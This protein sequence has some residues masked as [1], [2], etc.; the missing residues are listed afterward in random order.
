MEYFKYFLDYCPA[1]HPF[2]YLDGSYCCATKFEK[3]SDNNG[4]LHL[5]GSGYKCD[6]S[7]IQKDS[8]CCQSGDWQPCP[9]G[10]NQCE[11]Y[12]GITGHFT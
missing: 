1:S 12:P 8:T 2:V 4:G 11:N 5:D 3:I 10:K 7:V 9:A 6:G